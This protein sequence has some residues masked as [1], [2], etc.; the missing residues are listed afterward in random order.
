[1][2]YGFKILIVL[3]TIL[4]NQYWGFAQQ[5]KAIDLSNNDLSSML[6]P[7]ETLIDSAIANNSSI[8]STD[9]QIRVNEYKLKMD[10]LLWTKSIGVQTDIR[11]GTFD[12]FSVNTSEGINPYQIASQGVQLRYGI[13]GYIKIPILDI[14][15]RKNQLQSDLIEIEQSQRNSQ[16]QRDELRQLVIKHYNDLVLQHRFLKIKTKYIETIRIN[17]QLIEKEFLNGVTPIN[18]YTRQLGIVSSAEIDLE[19]TRMDFYT[20]YMILE[21]I[22]GIKFNINQ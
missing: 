4:T 13:G 1:M 3:F 11:Y 15:S 19:R 22:T 8:K 5:D 17:I 2:K 21:E 9:L 14:I 10:R 20:G 18:E 7:L 6:P 12:N 16:A